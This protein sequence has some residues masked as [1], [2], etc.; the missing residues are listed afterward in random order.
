MTATAARMAR[1]AMRSLRLL[2]PLASVTR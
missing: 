1:K 2:K